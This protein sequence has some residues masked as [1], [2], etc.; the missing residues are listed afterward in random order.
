MIVRTYFFFLSYSWFKK[1]KKMESTPIRTA[2]EIN[3]QDKKSFG[4]RAV[5]I[6]FVHPVFEWVYC[7]FIS[8]TYR[9]RIPVARRLMMTRPQLQWQREKTLIG[10]KS[11]H[12]SCSHEF[13]I[14]WW[15][16][17]GRRK[18]SKKHSQ[19][20]FGALHNPRLS[21]ELAQTSCHCNVD[22]IRIRPLGYERWNWRHTI[23]KFE[24]K[25]Q[26]DRLNNSTAT[27]EPSYTSH[28]HTPHQV[29]NEAN[30][31]GILYSLGSSDI[32]RDLSRGWREPSANLTASK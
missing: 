30:S 7:I 16:C 22:W 15:W 10:S 4:R 2:R 13:F 26:P 8:S 31:T 12:F 17:L 9:N 14:I 11:Y 21:I 20:L 29:F 19:P 25:V 18:Y 32:F 3:I 5:P 28:K 6:Y 23:R 1:K 27:D 24:S